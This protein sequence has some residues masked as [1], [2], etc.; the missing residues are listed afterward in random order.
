[1]IVS[2]PGTTHADATVDI[3]RARRGDCAS[4]THSTVRLAMG[5]SFVT[6]YPM[7]NEIESQ[8]RRR[9]G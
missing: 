2:A 9:Q 5:N 3:G 4:L 8:W 6:F 7:S 1:M